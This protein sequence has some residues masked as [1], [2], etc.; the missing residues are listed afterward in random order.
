MPLKYYI[1]S[2]FC[3]VFAPEEYT[4]ID[5]KYILHIIIETLGRI[6]TRVPAGNYSTQAGVLRPGQL[7]AC[8][9]TLLL[10]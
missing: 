3:H 10:S 1:T 6:L 4:I 9:P 5:A 8:S 2:Y 7:T